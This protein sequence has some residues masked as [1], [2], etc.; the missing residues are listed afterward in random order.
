LLND[1]LD[2]SKIESGTQTLGAGMVNPVEL[3]LNTEALFAN[4]AMAKGLKLSV[5]WNGPHGRRYRGDANRLQ[6]ML[7]N[8]TNN[9]IKF[10]AVGTVRIEATELS[11]VDG[12]ACVEWAVH[13]S[14]MGIPMQKMPLL[15]QPF[16]QVDDS[17]TRQY[18]GTGLGLSIV[19]SLAQLMGGEVGV[20]SKEGEGAR[21]WIRLRLDVMTDAVDLS[22][23]DTG[24]PTGLMP[25]GSSQKMSGRVLV[26]EDNRVNQQVICAML[27]QLGFEVIAVDNGQLAVERVMQEA[28]A[29]SAI[30]MDV[31]MPVL[32]GYEATRQ[33]RD[34]ESTQGRSALPIIAVTA[35]AFIEDQARCRQA[36]MDHFLPKPIKLSALSEVLHAFQ[37]VQ[38]DR[39]THP[40]VSSFLSTHLRLDI[41]GH[42][43]QCLV[44]VQ[45]ELVKI[46]VALTAGFMH[47]QR[48]ADFNL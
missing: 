46:S 17:T 20:E 4:N 2:L 3:L 10:T 12:S 15:F 5:Q 37:T 45:F 9:A 6:Q 29:I 38:A 11:Q 23:L 43:A 27:N 39:S 41:Q 33:I 16:S 26:V 34:W 8:L 35:D 25:Q 42:I 48:S 19:K 47:V 31:Q 30:L 32:D 18:G 28:D 22:E 40:L 13:D 1:I 36:G 7:S 44:Q 24:H 14:G 21:F